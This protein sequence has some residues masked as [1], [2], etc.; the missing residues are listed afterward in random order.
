MRTLEELVVF[1][2]GAS[3]TAFDE[4]DAKRIQ[5]FSDCKFVIYGERDAFLLG[6]VPKSGVVYLD[7]FGHLIASCMNDQACLVTGWT[8]E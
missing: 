5:A 7:L 1:R 3:E 4:V 2:V 6:P 8:F